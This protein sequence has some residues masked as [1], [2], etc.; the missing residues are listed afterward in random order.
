MRTAGIFLILIACAWLTVT[1]LAAALPKAGNSSRRLASLPVQES[2]S[3]DQV[4]DLVWDISA[5]RWSFPQQEK[6]SHQEITNILLAASMN[7]TARDGTAPSTIG[8][9]L[10]AL[11]GAFMLGLGIGKTRN[12]KR[13][14]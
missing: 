13:A 2:Y 9:A 7:R 6:Y 5:F 10:F 3:R 8:P 1:Q 12:V 11:V 14:T 4:R